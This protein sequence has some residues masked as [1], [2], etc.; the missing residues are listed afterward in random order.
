MLKVLGGLFKDL[1][2]A[3]EAWMCG[4]VCMDDGWMD[5]C[6]DVLNMDD[7]WWMDDGWICEQVGGRCPGLGNLRGILEGPITKY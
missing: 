1:S 6:M 5:G 7:G 4:N 2:K 3:Y